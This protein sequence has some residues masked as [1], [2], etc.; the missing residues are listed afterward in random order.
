MGA[1]DDLQTVGNLNACI[2]SFE[3][4]ACEN[5]SVYQSN[6]NTEL[7]R[8]ELAGNFTQP[9]L[10]VS[11]ESWWTASWPGQLLFDYDE[12]E[13]SL[14]DVSLSWALRQTAIVMKENLF[15]SGR[16]GSQYFHLLKG[17]TANS[18]VNY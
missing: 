15:S 1:S 13:L 12:S 7:A 10:P 4:R 17:H 16:Q 9:R 11:R 18:T 8:S 5:R 14:V 2:N 3:V 6:P